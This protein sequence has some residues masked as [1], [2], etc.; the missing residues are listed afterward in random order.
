MGSDTVSYYD[1]GVG[2]GVDL[3]FGWGFDGSG[4]NDT[5]ISIENIDGSSYDDSLHG[6]GEANTLKGME[7]DD[8]LWGYGGGDTLDGGNHLR[9]GPA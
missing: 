6:N 1:S 5:L 7:G 8:H 3:T 9:C 4:R 2:V